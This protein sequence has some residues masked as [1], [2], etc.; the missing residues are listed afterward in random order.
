M[1]YGFILWVLVWEAKASA[2]GEHG[3]FNADSV[4]FPTC[5][6]ILAK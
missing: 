1:A 5:T 2:E 4:I 6:A 3:L